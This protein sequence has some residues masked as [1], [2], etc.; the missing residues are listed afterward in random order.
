MSEEVFF[1]RN[2]R[3]LRTAALQLS[4]EISFPPSPTVSALCRHLPET[5][6]RT[7]RPNPTQPTQP[8]DFSF[9]ESPSSRPVGWGP[10]GNR[11]HEKQLIPAR[12]W[13]KKDE[14]PLS[15]L[16]QEEV[17]E[18]SGGGGDKGNEVDQKN[19]GRVKGGSNQGEEGSESLMEIENSRWFV[20]YVVKC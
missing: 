10:A 17:G 20:E 13:E 4:A 1:L 9:Q 19:L 5:N 18:K 16:Q 14:R 8:T 11:P 2:C 12:A 7:R 3:F 6:G 15:P